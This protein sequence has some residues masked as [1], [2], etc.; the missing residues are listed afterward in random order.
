MI[1]TEL[2]LVHSIFRASEN[3]PIWSEC[4]PFS[5]R[6]REFLPCLSNNV[7]KFEKLLASGSITKF[8]QRARFSSNWDT[9]ALPNVGKPKRHSE[10]ILATSKLRQR[11]RHVTLLA[12][13]ACCVYSLYWLITEA[14]VNALP[15]DYCH[16]CNVDYASRNPPS[17]TNSILSISPRIITRTASIITRCFRSVREISIPKLSRIGNFI[18][19][20]PNVSTM[21]NSNSD[22]SI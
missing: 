12:W 8:Q 17:S 3:S 22:L 11:S 15:P 13:D 6:A 2:P 19:P 5:R 1:T 18:F 16:L 21:S 14:R 10:A 9:L 4:F 20:W 7:E